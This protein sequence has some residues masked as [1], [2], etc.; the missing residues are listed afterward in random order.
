MTVEARFNIDNIAGRLRDG[1]YELPEGATVADLIEA[2]RHESG[3][4]ILT[5]Q[6]SNLMLLLDSKPAAYSTKLHDGGKLHV[7]LKIMGG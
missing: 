4:D 5:D 7:M 2:A 6:E 3:C 1:A